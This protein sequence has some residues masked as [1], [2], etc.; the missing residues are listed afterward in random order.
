MT[1]VTWSSPE[2]TTAST[3][4]L[5]WTNDGI[6]NATLANNAV[7]RIFFWIDVPAGQTGVNYNTTFRIFGQTN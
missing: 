4:R 2:N 5:N 3:I 7:Q 6:I 1:N